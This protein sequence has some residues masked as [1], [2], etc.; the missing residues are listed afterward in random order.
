MSNSERN[1]WNWHETGRP[2]YHLPSWRDEYFA[3]PP[4]SCTGRSASS[5][6]H[7]AASSSWSSGS[8]RSKSAGRQRGTF[9][10]APRKFGQ[11]R[12]GSPVHA[13]QT[14]DQYSSFPKLA[15][16]RAAKRL[17]AARMT[18]PR[19]QQPQ[20]P[21]QPQQQPQRSHRSHRS[22]EPQQPQ[23]DFAPHHSAYYRRSRR[24]VSEV[25]FSSG[26]EAEP[27]VWEV[28]HRHR[29][30]PYG[31]D[32]S[33][34]EVQLGRLASRLEDEVA[35]LRTQMRRHPSGQW[36]AVGGLKAA[37]A[38]ATAVWGSGGSMA[39]AA[40]SAPPGS[41]TPTTRV[42]NLGIQS[43]T[44]GLGLHEKTTAPPSTLFVSHS[45]WPAG[46]PPFVSHDQGLQAQAARLSSSAHPRAPAE[47][48]STPVGIMV[49]GIPG[50]AALHSPLIDRLTFLEEEVRALRLE[51][52]ASVESPAGGLASAARSPAP[53]QLFLEC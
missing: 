53:R 35:A 26:D 32:F 15:T 28:P 34:G 25:L 47:E 9:G 46:T 12:D 31:V 42:H 13:Y 22:R 6:R 17:S 18:S 43:R 30:A 2:L 37:K 48:V 44:H 21:Q 36:R 38:T 39:A 40:G 3:S 52:F 27:P 7:R 1:S 33:R 20:Q 45:D 49:G 50:G 4:S 41:P 23:G 16:M 24:S 8:A 51:V 19:R 11:E 14:Q 29:K 10:T 5:A